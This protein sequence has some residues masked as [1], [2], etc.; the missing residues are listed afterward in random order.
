MDTVQ[1]GQKGKAFSVHDGVNSVLTEEAMTRGRKWLHA[2]GCLIDSNIEPRLIALT[3]VTIAKQSNFSSNQNVT[4]RR[5][6][7]RML[8]IK[9]LTLLSVKQCQSRHADIGDNPLQL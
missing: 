6:A 5:D 4:K 9:Y 8:I 1:K 3:S 7:V 2:N